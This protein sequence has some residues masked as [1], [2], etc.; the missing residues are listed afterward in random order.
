MVHGGAEVDRP[1]VSLVAREAWRQLPRVRGSGGLLAF[2]VLVILFFLGFP[3][4]GLLAWS[5]SRA[6]S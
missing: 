5:P 2:V 4:E 1:R 3:V 6:S